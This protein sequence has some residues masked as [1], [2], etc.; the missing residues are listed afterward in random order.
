MAIN[1]LQIKKKLKGDPIKADD[2]NTILQYLQEQATPKV[3]RSFYPENIP[4]SPQ[5]TIQVY[6]V[7]AIPQFTLFGIVQ[8]ATGGTPLTDPQLVYGDS[9]A[10][11]ASIALP[12][13]TETGIA[14]D[15]IGTAIV[16]GFYQPVKI[17]GVGSELAGFPLNFDIQFAGPSGF[18]NLSDYTDGYVNVMRCI[19]PIAIWCQATAGIAADF[20]TRVDCTVINNSG[21]AFKQVDGTDL[22][23]PV[24]NFGAEGILSGDRFLAYSV[25][26]LGLIAAN[27]TQYIYGTLDGDLVGGSS[28]TLNITG[29]GTA[30]VYA[31]TLDS[32][33]KLAG[34]TYAAKLNKR[35]GHYEILFAWPQQIATS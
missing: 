20:S 25:W 19:Q 13:Y 10:N 5:K 34:G 33:H 26:G 30:T 15:T 23:M 28:Q 31:P 1:I 9:F 27:E 29:G 22:T 18:I 7:S 24:M 4:V 6:A 32:G 21:T 11:G 3:G 2:I 8:P 35:T 12:L 14:Q 17:N 16:V